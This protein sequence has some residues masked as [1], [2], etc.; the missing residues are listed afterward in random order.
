MINQIETP[1]QANLLS[2]V[3]SVKFAQHVITVK[4]AI[5]GLLVKSGYD[6]ESN[7]ESEKINN[8]KLPEVHREIG[9]IPLKRAIKVLL[10]P[11]SSSKTSGFIIFFNKVL[12]SAF[13]T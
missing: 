1:A 11:A 2:V 4:Q 6:L 10:G 12:A 9:P 8:F 13:N 5:E 3:I 7:Y